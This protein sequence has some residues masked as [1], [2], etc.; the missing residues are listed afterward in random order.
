MSRLRSVHVRRMSRQDHRKGRYNPHLNT[1][2]TT[3]P[4]LQRARSVHVPKLKAT[5]RRVWIKPA[6]QQGSGDE[7]SN[8]PTEAGA[9]TYHQE[10]KSPRKEIVKDFQNQGNGGTETKCPVTKGSVGS[11]HVA[12]EVTIKKFNIISRDRHDGNYREQT[13]PRQE[14]TLPKKVPTS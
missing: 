4:P 5:R 11:A 14:E 12:V 7:F 8:T 13:L 2:P 10:H 6:V 3:F 1:N 9:C